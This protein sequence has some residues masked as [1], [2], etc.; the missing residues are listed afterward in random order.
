MLIMILQHFKLLGSEAATGN[1]LFVFII[2]KCIITMSPMIPSVEYNSA[3]LD[4]DF[5]A[6]YSA[7]CALLIFRLLLFSSISHFKRA[8]FFRF[9]A[10]SAFP[11]A[12]CR[13]V[14]QLMHCSSFVFLPLV[15]YLP[16]DTVR[17]DF[18]GE[19]K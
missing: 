6:S 18:G 14:L 8:D 17:R 9:I 5:T 15:I 19:S 2:R 11:R 16:R 13:A 1:I 7:S 3:C 12:E 4:P 10:F